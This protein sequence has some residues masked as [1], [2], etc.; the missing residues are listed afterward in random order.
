MFDGRDDASVAL[1][2]VPSFLRTG[3]SYSLRMSNLFM[4]RYQ[5][6]L[7]I[8]SLR[9]T[10]RS[11]SGGVNAFECPLPQYVRDST[12]PGGDVRQWRAAI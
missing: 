3:S 4:V 9:R 11:V 6:H 5:T 10:S 12:R 7:D 8:L 1:R 2:E